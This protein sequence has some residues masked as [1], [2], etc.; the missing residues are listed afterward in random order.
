MKN[1]ANK[2]A[3][4]EGGL[5]GYI[6]EIVENGSCVDSKVFYYNAGFAEGWKQKSEQAYVSAKAF[7]ASHGCQ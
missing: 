5:R 2:V 7:A 1:Q 6:V 3:H 4:I